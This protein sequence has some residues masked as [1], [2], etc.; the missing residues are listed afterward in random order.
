[1]IVRNSFTK[2]LGI[3]S[4][5]ESH[6]RHI[7]YI[8]GQSDGQNKKVREYFYYIDHHGQVKLIQI[9]NIRLT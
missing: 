8:Q 9:K 4:F 2:I 6:T 7:N 1:M 5:I 3:K